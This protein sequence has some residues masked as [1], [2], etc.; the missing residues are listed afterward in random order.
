MKGY[1]SRKMKPDELTYESLIRNISND[2]K[3]VRIRLS[4][5]I[6]IWREWIFDTNVKHALPLEEK[7]IPWCSNQQNHVISIL[8]KSSY[9]YIFIP[10]KVIQKKMPKYR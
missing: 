8:R 7:W 3:V 9:A 10:P 1:T 4:H 6:T 5:V 2:L